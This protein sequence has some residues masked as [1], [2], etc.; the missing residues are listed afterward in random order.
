MLQIGP[1]TDAPR[2]QEPDEGRDRKAEATYGSG[3]I[4][5]VQMGRSSAPWPSV[6]SACIV[7]TTSG[8]PLVEINAFRQTQTAL[9][10]FWMVK[11]GV[12]ARLSDARRRQPRG[13]Y[14]SSFLFIKRSS[15]S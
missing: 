2:G 8:Q 1:R 12:A 10:S 15:P 14:H 13:P 4:C 6:F 9:T 3:G 11:E 5:E 7:I